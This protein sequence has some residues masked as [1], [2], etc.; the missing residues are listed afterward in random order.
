[1]DSHP[2]N[3]NFLLATGYA[4]GDSLAAV[5]RLGFV[6]NGSQLGNL[7]EE[8]VGFADRIRICPTIRAPCVKRIEL[9]YTVGRLKLPLKDYGGNESEHSF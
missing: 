5:S 3:I 2:R 9:I 4:G 7:A 1:M 6:C 8:S